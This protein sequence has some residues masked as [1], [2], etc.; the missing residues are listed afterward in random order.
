MSVGRKPAPERPHSWFPGDGETLQARPGRFDSGLPGA[1]TLG[2]G[3]VGDGRLPIHRPCA[4]ERR[5]V[6]A[7]PGAAGDP[8]RRAPRRRHREDAA[9][10]GILRRASPQPSAG[11]LDRADR[12]R[13]PGA[14]ADAGAGAAARAGAVAAAR[15]RRS[16]PRP[17]RVHRLDGLG[18]RAPA[19]RA[20]RLLRPRRRVRRPAHD[21]AQPPAAR[22][23]ARRVW[24]WR[25]RRDP[26]CRVPRWRWPSP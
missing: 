26:R 21:R 9:F 2:G 5:F 18:A 7:A 1:E 24:C 4:R 14:R 15:V 3:R 19:A 22:A 23:G 17:R 13:R 12:R 8:E 16:R 11:R 20:L 25:G 6:L 10:G